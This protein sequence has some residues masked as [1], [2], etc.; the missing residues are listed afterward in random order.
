MEKY[1]LVELLH[2]NEKKGK[3]KKIHNTQR[4]A[5]PYAEEIREKDELV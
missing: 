4:T 2:D 5:N 1:F 3:R